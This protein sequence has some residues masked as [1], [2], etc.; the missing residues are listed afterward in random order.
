GP[1]PSGE[2]AR[3]RGW[4]RALWGTFALALLFCARPPCFLGHPFGDL[5]NG[6]YT[7]HFSHMNCARL[8]PR[9]GADLWRHPVMELL[10]P[11]P[12][13]ERAALPPDLRTEKPDYYR[14]EGWPADK[15]MVLSWSENPRMYP[16]GDLVLVAPLALLYHFTPI[17]FRAV[18]R[19]LIALF[20]AYTFVACQLARR[21]ILDRPDDA[22]SAGLGAAFVFLA[23]LYW[24]L[25]GFYDMAAVAP[26]VLCAGHLARRE[27]LRALLWYCVAAAIHFRAYFLAPWALYAAWLVLSQR[28]WRRWGAGGWLA[29]G[30][31]AALALASLVPFWMLRPALATLENNNPLHPQSTQFSPWITAVFGAVVAGCALAL[32]RARAW[33]DVCVC[34]FAALMTF[35][36][37]QA[38]E[39]HGVVLGAWVV[40]P[41][42]GAGAAHP[43]AVRLARLAFLVAATFL[44]FWYRSYVG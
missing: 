36:L 31:C 5:R 2:R 40:A 38:Y 37:H 43:R 28:A 16:P 35:R 3:S 15:P 9:A 32:A 6:I 30:A 41:L 18:N 7:D 21:A 19:L 13:A 33:L 20:V 11:I 29:A 25:H 4:S 26:L 24:A 12:F 1:A 27:G 8:F 44:V 42:A 10:P 23:G 14:V 34:A 22:L 39:W 17:S